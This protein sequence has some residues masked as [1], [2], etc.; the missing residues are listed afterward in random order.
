MRALVFDKEL[1]YRTDVPM[2]IPKED[3]ALIRVTS[4]GI[5]NTDLEII[6]GYMGFKGIPG[7]EFVGVVEECADSKLTGMRV[8]GEINIACGNCDYCNNRMENHCP[9]RSVLGILNRDGAFADYITLPIK[10]MHL[11]P[12]SISDEEAVFVEPLA[13]AFKILEQVDIEASDRVCVLGDGKLGLLAGQ[14]LSTTGCDLVVDGKHPGKLSILD[15]MGIRTESGVKF[16]EKG[17]DIV[18][19]CTGSA[20]GI[21]TALRIVKPRGRVVLKTTVT[22]KREVDLNTLVVNEISLIGS[23]C[24]PFHSAIDA[25]GSRKVDVMPLISASYGLEEGITAFEHAVKRDALKIILR[26]A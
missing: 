12:D 10:N 3:E 7:H 25:I 11:V 2:P 4:A 26:L 16:N 20:S 22:E 9:S 8:V 19:D 17:F 24:G 1:Q 23:R 6:K 15:R 5:C 18:V 14:V 21:E 13:A